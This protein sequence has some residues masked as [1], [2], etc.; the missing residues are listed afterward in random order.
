[1]SKEHLEMMV[2]LVSYG[3]LVIAVLWTLTPEW[4]TVKRELLWKIKVAIETAGGQIPFPQRV[5]WYGAEQSKD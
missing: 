2:K 3:I 4:Y 1:M 5:L